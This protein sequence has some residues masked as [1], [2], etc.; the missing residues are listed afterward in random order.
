MIKT[1]INHVQTQVV[2]SVICDCCH[3]EYTDVMDI[4]EFLHIDEV[5]GYYSMIG[6]DV[7][8]QCDL[9]S[10]C[11]KNLLGKYIRKCD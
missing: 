1:K 5:G 7:H 10:E 8:Y 3:K 4:Q 11:T 6:D 2:E 9:C